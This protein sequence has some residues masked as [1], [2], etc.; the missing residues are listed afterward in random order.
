MIRFEAGKTYFASAIGDHSVV[1]E[2]HV[3]RR[4]KC[5]VFTHNRKYKI[6]TAFDG[7]REYVSRG[8]WSMAGG[9][10]ATN[11]QRPVTI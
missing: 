7:T 9:W 1:Y 8:D 10:F 4:T 6:S 11:T 2:L 3:I 5:F